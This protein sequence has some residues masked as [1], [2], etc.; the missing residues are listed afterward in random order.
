MKILKLR[1]TTLMSLIMLFLTI[2]LSGQEIQLSDE[3]IIL[4]NTS[5]MFDQDSGISKTLIGEGYLKQ[6]EA[7]LVEIPPGKDVAAHHHLAE[8]LIYIISGSGYTLMWDRPGNK[9]IRYEWSAGDMLSPTLNAWHQHINSSSDTPARFISL[10]S[11]PLTYNLVRDPAF[12]SS[13]DYVFEDRWQQSITQLPEYDPIGIEGMGVVRMRIGHQITNLPGREMRNRRENV[14]GI[15]VRPE[16][17]MAGN[18]TME[19]E[20]REYQSVDSSSPGHRHP[21]E[22]VYHI[23]S[24]NGYAMLQRKGEAMRR[25]NWQQGDLFFVEAD[26]YHELLPLDGSSPRVLQVKASGFLHNVGNFEIE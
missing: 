7:I 4:K 6:I 1:L 13:I 10:S 17:D 16:G 25:V 23:M 26:E 14:L 12:L 20:V 3:T 21:W 9:K 18:Q 11:T 8:E 22:V 19:W 5:V 24:G 15:S 2:N